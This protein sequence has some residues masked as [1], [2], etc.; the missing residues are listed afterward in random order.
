MIFLLRRERERSKTISVLKKDCS[1]RDTGSIPANCLITQDGILVDIDQIR[2]SYG[3]DIANLKVEA[4]R[5]VV[6]DTNNHCLRLINLEKDLVTT[7]AGICNSPG[8]K[9]GPLG[10]NQLNEPTTIGADNLGNIW[11]YDKGNK[12]IRKLVPQEDSGN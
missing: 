8:F 12:Y 2:I 7:I 10:K 3:Q 11:V 4:K 1:D 5:L 6:A 9:D